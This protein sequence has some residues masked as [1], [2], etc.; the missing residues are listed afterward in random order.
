M[1]VGRLEQVGVSCASYT[2]MLLSARQ[3]SWFDHR[4]LDFLHRI[5]PWNALFASVFL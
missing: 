4:T 3:C 5:T 1:E 2:V